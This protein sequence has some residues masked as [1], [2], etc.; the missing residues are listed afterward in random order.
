MR[1]W[2]VA[3]LALALLGWWLAPPSAVDVPAGLRVDRDPVQSASSSR[4]AFTHRDH[5]LT[6]VA[7]FEVR[8]RLLAR[9]RYYLDSAARVV[10]FDF[11]LGWGPMSD[12]AVLNSV[13]I[14]QGARFYHWRVQEFPI[15][16]RDIERHSANMHLVPANDYVHRQ[17][18]RVRPGEFVLLRGMLV[19]ISRPDGWRMASSRTRDDTGPGACEVIF[20]EQVIVAR[21]PQGLP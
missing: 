2:L 11:A 15:P 6:P 21:A 18:D 9:E 8:A 17:L 20:V 5:L 12:T 4:P 10:P 3:C 1:R 14:S 16:R 19:D 7:D 13:Q